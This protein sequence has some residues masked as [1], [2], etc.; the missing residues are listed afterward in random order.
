MSTRKKC[1]IMAIVSIWSTA[2]IAIILSMVNHFGKVSVYAIPWINLTV[3]YW[4]DIPLL[5]VYVN[6]SLA[7]FFFK[8]PLRDYDQINGIFTIELIAGVILGVIAA[9][10]TINGHF[11]GGLILGTVFA[12]FLGS[13][14]ENSPS[15]KVKFKD[16]IIAAISSG[17]IFGLAVGLIAG[18]GVGFLTAIGI[19][20]ISSLLVIVICLIVDFHRFLLKN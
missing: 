2:I 16:G 19:G 20:L 12:T 5:L 15:Y 11:T 7:F 4:W 17:L 6:I 10:L 13:T 14:Y 9:I 8:V 18:I 3:P 1:G